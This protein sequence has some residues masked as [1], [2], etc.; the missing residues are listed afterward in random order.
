MRAWRNSTNYVRVT[1]SAAGVD[2]SDTVCKKALCGT[3]RHVV[4]IRFKKQ[5]YDETGT[6]T[7]RAMA[8]FE[9]E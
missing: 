2:D 8:P 5:T 3:G 7:V 9:V 6:C 1:L 4:C